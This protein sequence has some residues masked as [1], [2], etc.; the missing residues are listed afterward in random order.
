MADIFISKTENRKKKIENCR[1][2]CKN[3]NVCVDSKLH[4][5]MMF[6]SLGNL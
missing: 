3:A 6:D 4:V 2:K 5:A 1:K